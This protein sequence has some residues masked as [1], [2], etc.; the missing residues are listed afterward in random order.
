MASRSRRRMAR[1]RSKV[2]ALVFEANERSPGGPCKGVAKHGQAVAEHEAR[3][4]TEGRRQVPHLH[5][6]LRPPPQELDIVGGDV[7][8]AHD[9]R[10]AVVARNVLLHDQRA[11]AEL[12]GHRR[13]RIRC[14][15]LDVRPVD[16]AARER[17]VC[18]DRVAGIVGI[19]DDQPADNEEAVPVQVLDRG[20]RR[21]AHGAA[22][23]TLRVLGRAFRKARSSAS[24]FSMPRN[25]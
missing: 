19:A 21:V 24:T 11:A 10:G 25:T 16:I 23:R 18:L 13:A 14:G 8:G 15:V 20:N 12:F 1:N 2:S 4:V 3:A 6:A 7:L 22:L 5:P 17:Q 9:G